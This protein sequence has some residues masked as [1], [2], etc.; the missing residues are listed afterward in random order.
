METFHKKIENINPEEN[1]ERYCVNK[2]D[3]VIV[4]AFSK[5]TAVH[6]G[7][8]DRFA[9]KE[10]TQE[11]LKNVLNQERKNRTAA[12]IHVPFCETHCLYCGFYN[13]PYRREQSRIYTDVLINEIKLWENTTAINSDP[14]NA[15]Y[16]GGGTP[17]ALEVEDIS[18]LLKYISSAL[19]LA[20][21][22]EITMEGRISNM[23]KEKVEAYLQGGVNRFSLGVQSFNTELRRSMGRRSDRDTIIERINM[24]KEYNQAAIVLDLI[25]GFPNQTMEIWVDDILLAQN[26]EID[27]FDCYQLNVFPNTPLG[28]RI[29][30]GSINPAL[31]IKEKTELFIKSVELMQNALYTRISVNHWQRTTRE[32]NIYNRL[33][34]GYAS[35][36]SFGAGAGGNINGYGY[37]ILRDYQGYL[38]SVKNGIK[39]IM[40]ISIPGV[41]Y[42]LYKEISEYFETGYL[43]LAYLENKYSLPLTSICSKL[44]NQWEDAGVIK[45][46]NNKIILTLAGQFW[47]VNLSQLLQ[48]YIKLTLQFQGDKNMVNSE[49]V[50]L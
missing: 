45:Y 49:K 10:Q 12:Y 17:T 2:S 20:N 41:N 3:N 7:L 40:G 26:L 11:V 37:M 29:A 44:L 33:A 21:D 16:F 27:G 48:E 30:D 28:K 4:D 1:F 34:R 22:C 19:P 15:L 9:P 39:P 23:T 46:E 24:I 6:A 35:C 25:Y 36:L 43:Y 32:R 31:N 47:F 14:I 5:K 42:S 50:S 18:R 13:Q 38:E 8:M